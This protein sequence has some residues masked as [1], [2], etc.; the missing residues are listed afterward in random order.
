MIHVHIFEQVD[1]FAKI[2]HNLVL[3]G[4]EYN[5]SN[6]LGQCMAWHII[7]ISLAS[8]ARGIRKK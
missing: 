5:C 3:R 7:M 6:C 4:Q 8:V 1:C 2:I